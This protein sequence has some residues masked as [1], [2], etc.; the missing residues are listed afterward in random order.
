MSFDEL[1]DAA[2][3]RSSG[4]LADSEAKASQDTAHAPL[5]IHHSI[6]E[7]L[8]CDERGPHLLRSQRLRVSWTVPTQPHQLRNTTSIA[9]VRLHRHGANG[10][11][12]MPGLQKDDLETGS[13]EAS[14]KPL[15]RAGFAGGWF[16]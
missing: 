10:R 5:Q 12:D 2:F 11:F 8:P 9:P 1:A 4:D 16:H 15:N 3:E 13:R 6:E 7:L 14:V